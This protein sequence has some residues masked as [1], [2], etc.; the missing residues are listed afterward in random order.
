MV[1]EPV[2]YR[3]VMELLD[4]RPGERVV[5]LTVGAGGHGQLFVEKIGETGHYV[6]VDRD[7]QI[8]VHARPK[9]E[10]RGVELIHGSFGDRNLLRRLS[11]TRFDV[12]FADLGVSSLQLDDP[13]R[14]FSFRESGPLDMRMDSSGGETV[15]ELLERIDQ[16]ELSQILREF[17]EERYSGR[18]ARSILEALRR[19]E[20]RSTGDLADCV[21]RVVPKSRGHR[22]DPATRT[23]QALRIAVNRELD[24]LETLLG[25]LDSLLRPGG[26]AGVISF[27]SLEDRRV[28]ESFR[29]WVQEGGYELLTRKPIR[30]TEEE[31]RVNSRARSARLRG[32]LKKKGES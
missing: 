25:C 28:K 5:D 1:H 14:G 18:A 8:L 30:A 24:A 2:L 26:R 27:H 3:E 29:A 16:S 15:L 32:L 22:I 12:L 11:Q 21:R 7:E 20:L 19:G 31:L 6:G 23:F 9:F 4:P 17:G 10:P 13:E